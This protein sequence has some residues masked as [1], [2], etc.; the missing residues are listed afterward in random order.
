MLR[1]TVIAMS[2]A[3]AGGLASMPASADIID[4]T[5]PLDVSNW[6]TTLSGSPPGGGGSV[7]TT[8]APG[9]VKII[10]GNSSCGSGNGTCQ[11]DFTI[12]L[13]SDANTVSFNWD[14]NTTDVDGPFFDRF[15]YLL[16]G[17]FNQLTDNGGADAQSGTV[18]LTDIAGDT[19]GWGMNCTDCV[20]GGAT[21]VI[22]DLKAV[23]EPGSMAIVGLGLAGLAAVRRR[24]AA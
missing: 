22:S 5:G 1:K 4:F 11:T 20:L 6:T 21:A 7:D 9:S 23:P 18:T 3:A 12:T 8:G 14:Y 19:F 17:V 15:G 2:L 13:P 24:K 16:N 10:G